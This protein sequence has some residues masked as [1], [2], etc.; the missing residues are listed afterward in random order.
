MNVTKHDW[1]MLL[2]NVAVVLSGGFAA[3]TMGITNRWILL[4][5]SFVFGVVWTIYFKFAMLH[6]LADH[7]RFAS[8][9]DEEESAAIGDHPSG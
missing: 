1:I 9:E 8:E 7:P 6:R 2:F 3:M 4:G 5:I